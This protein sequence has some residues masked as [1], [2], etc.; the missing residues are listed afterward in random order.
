MNNIKIPV[1][2]PLLNGNERKYLLRCFD[3]GYIS[4]TGKYINKFELEFAK[5]VNRKY[6]IAVSNGTVALQLAFDSLNIKKNDE[7]ILPSFTIISCI[8]PIIRIGAKPI[9]VDSNINTW[10]MDVNKI[11]QLITKKTKAILVPHIYGLPVDMDPLIKIAKKFKLKLIED[12]AEV[13]G[14]KYKNRLCGSFG[15]ISTFSFYANKH[16][17]TGEG[18]MIVTDNKKI[19]ER[20]FSLRNIFFNNFKRFVHH[21]LG[22]NAR[23]TNIQAS[24]GIAQLERLDEFVKIKRKIGDAYNKGLINNENYIKPLES[25]PYGKNIYW[26]YGVLIAKPKLSVKKIVKKL[27]KVGIETRPFFWPLHQQPILKKLGLFKNIKLPVSEY[28]S[29]NGFYL[30]SGLSLNKKQQAYVIKNFNKIII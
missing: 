3:E 1:N 6:A 14:L 7:I 10:N 21:G 17:T 29:K 18:G 5:K 23:L 28:L 2:E 19:A 12:S 16:I 27:K 30:P 26:V 13:L 15:D 24:I 22:W 11:E 20:C 9:L 4:S 25:T 8:L